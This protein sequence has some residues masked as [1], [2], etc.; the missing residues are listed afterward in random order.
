MV[1]RDKEDLSGQQIGNYEIESHI[2]ARK[3]SD[4][5][6]ARDVKLERLVFLEVLRAT[7]EDENDLAGRFNRRMETVSQLKDPAI[8]VV[9]DLDVTHEGFP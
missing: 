8:A 4:L 9:S 6:L 3:A 1:A 2:A 7:D 5:F